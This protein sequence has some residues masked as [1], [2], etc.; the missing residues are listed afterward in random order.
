MYESTCI[1]CPCLSLYT[2][3]QVVHL[4]VCVLTN[5]DQRLKD[6]K[7]DS[8]ISAI[9]SLHASYISQASRQA[10]ATCNHAFG[11][12]QIPHT[13][14]LIR[15]QHAG[16]PHCVCVCV[17]VMLKKQA[18]KSSKS[19]SARS[20][21]PSRDPTPHTISTSSPPI[22]LWFGRVWVW[23]CCSALNHCAPPSPL[24]S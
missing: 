12:W 3:R 6:Y 18:K 7:V 14:I 16:I 17:F 1:V 11:V 10:C 24:C 21:P 8:S 15:L 13:V 2:R 19:R 9:T 22:K 20:K 23:R 5:T 4:P